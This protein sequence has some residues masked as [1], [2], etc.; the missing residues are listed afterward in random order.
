MKKQHSDVHTVQPLGL[1]ARRV[2]PPVTEIWAEILLPLLLM[3]AQ[4][5]CE[6]PRVGRAHVSDCTD[7][8]NQ[9]QQK[10]LRANLGI[11]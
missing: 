8:V 1:G 2:P 10:I 5:C 4:G 9:V 6:R 7:L 3:L 11:Y